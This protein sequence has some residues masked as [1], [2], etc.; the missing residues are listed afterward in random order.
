MVGR[1]V[2]RD[3]IEIILEIA[4][5]SKRFNELYHKDPFL[6][7]EFVKRGII[8]NNKIKEAEDAVK[9]GVYVTDFILP[10]KYDIIN[11][12]K[13]AKI[14]IQNIK[15]MENFYLVKKS[16]SVKEFYADYRQDMTNTYDR[17]MNRLKIVKSEIEVQNKVQMNLIMI[18]HIVRLIMNFL[19]SGNSLNNI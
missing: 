17:I 15:D 11:Y 9:Q 16:R 2:S 13:I 19:L 3:P 1:R 7:D 8:V 6:Y 10:G 4:T 12:D 18:N 14:F 5:N